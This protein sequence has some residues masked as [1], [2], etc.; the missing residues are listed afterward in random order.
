M[1][2]GTRPSGVAIEQIACPVATAR[3]ISSRSA[4]AAPIWNDIIVPGASHRLNPQ[5]KA[6]GRGSND[7]ADRERPFI[8]M[9]QS[10]FILPFHS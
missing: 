3:D 5:A 1:M 10:E 8:R 9:G 6:V 7:K 2:D 4:N